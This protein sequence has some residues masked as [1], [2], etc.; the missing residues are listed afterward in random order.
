M[1]EFLNTEEVADY[2]RLKER[3]IYELVRTKQIPC[4][5]VTG[6]LLF[7]RHLIDLWVTR[8]LDFA[9]GVLA[10]PPPVVAGSH[11]PLLE[12]AL[13]ASGCEL[14]VL[15]GGSEDGLMRLAAE[16]AVAAGL[17]I[18]DR[19]SGAYNLPAVQA[20][21]GL[22]DIVLIEWAKREQGLVVAA[23][24]PRGIAG[25]ADLAKPGIRVMRRQEGA[26]AQILLRHLLDQAGI[27]FDDL[28]VAAPPALTE[29]D[30]ADAILVGG[31]DVGVAVRAAAHHSQ[32]GFVPLRWERF[33][34]ALRR[35][36]YFEAPLQRLLHFARSEDFA[37]QAAVLGGY[38]IVE[39]G[40][41]RYN[42]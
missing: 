39:T 33:D 12:W 9:G 30:I 4:S 16:K 6:K 23:G 19:H 38:D 35:R 15:P 42:A 18:L 2:L 41:V 1:R 17:H 21:R 25:L 10:H 28:A 8:R 29:N 26:G 34:L 5:R 7:P 11:D 36:D 40:T 27:R 22:A 32:L 3:T 14:A 31:A 13:R 37:R 20:R 24:N